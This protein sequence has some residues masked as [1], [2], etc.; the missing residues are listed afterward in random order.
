MIAAASNSKFLGIIFFTKIIYPQNMCDYDQWFKIN[1]LDHS[2][3]TI[4][5]PIIHTVAF[6][7]DEITVLCRLASN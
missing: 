5:I 2:M 7:F 1:F 4:I 3:T 6:N